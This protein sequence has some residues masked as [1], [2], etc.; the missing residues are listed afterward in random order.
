VTSARAVR[1]I[2]R[3]VGIVYDK[4]LKRMNAEIVRL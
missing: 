1:F 4:Q 3:D 2:G